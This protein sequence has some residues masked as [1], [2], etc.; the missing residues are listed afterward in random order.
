[1]KCVALDTSTEYLS[2]GICEDKKVLFTQTTLLERNHSALLLPILEDV[3]KR[4]GLSI[5][6]IDGFIVGLGPGSFTGLRVGIS[7]VK[8]MAVSLQKQVVGVPTLDCLAE[9]LLE[10]GKLPEKMEVAPFVDAKRNQV[11]AALYIKQNGTLRKKIPE[12][13]TPPDPFLKALRGETLFLGGGATLYRGVIQKTL[14][15]RAHF[16]DSFHDIPDPATL[17]AMGFQRFQKKQLE[18][19]ST[20][21]PLYLYPKDCMIRETGRKTLSCNLLLLS[22]KRETS[23]KR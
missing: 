6:N 19:P 4:L 23:P 11:Y 13:V 16:T 20:L 8:A 2:L 17:L 15:K 7:M 9:A 22:P 1:M 3:L 12:Q 14:G 10:K 21:V 18:N 5:R